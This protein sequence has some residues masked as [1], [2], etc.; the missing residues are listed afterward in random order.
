MES[1]MESNT[2]VNEGFADETVEEIILL[3][4]SKKAK[5]FQMCPPTG[6][7]NRV[8]TYAVI[9]LVFW[10]VIWSYTGKEVYPNG[11]L[12]GMLVIF[13]VALFGGQILRLIKIPFV[14][15]LPP[16]LGM[17]LA[18]FV[19]RNTPGL[20]D[21]IHV[22]RAWSSYLRSTALTIILV[23]A[24]LG[25]DPQA[26]KKLKGVC[27]RLSMGP[28]CFEASAAAVFSHLILKF[29]WQWGFLL[30]FVL[31]AVSPAVVVP[32]VL[33]LQEQGYGVKKGVPTLMIAASSFD[34]IL[35]ITG[36]N[37]FLGITFSSGPVYKS[38]LWGILEAGIGVVTGIIMGIFVRFFPSSDQ[39]TCHWKRA[40]LILGIAIVAVIGSG[41]IG[42]HGAG[43]LTTIVMTFISAMG[44]SNDKV[45]VQSIV[46]GTWK[47]FQ[48]LLFGLVGAEVSVGN[49]E[50]NTIGYCVCIV[51]LSVIVRLLV[52]FLLLSYAGF[53]IKEK[54]FIS[55]AW[56]PKATVQA[57]LGPLALETS[58]AKNLP[59][60]EG[61]AKNVMTMAFLA[62]L[63]TAPN[64][65]LL[66]GLLG[67]KALE[68]DKPDENREMPTFSH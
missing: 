25:L 43:G 63:I 39:S 62:I 18:G 13:H 49:L 56:L 4:E 15:P 53:T 36:F 66:I 48:P 17:L 29:P 14:P 35:A 9:L 16:L 11:S 52:T 45:R 61:Y 55:V 5:S 7:I 19:L 54:V 42:L 20:R 50:S 27:L 24:G 60:A 1:K 32:S 58:I 37:T 65:A 44:W 41:R 38:V 64:G 12:F 28:C 51:M 33:M 10:L 46:A 23:R 40:F 57:V 22:N 21:Y 26:L 3:E 59:E 68:L 8:I 6:V 30:G 67:P 34:D 2:E 31:G 47:I